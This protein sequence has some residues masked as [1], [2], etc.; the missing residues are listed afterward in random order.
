MR[1]LL[2]LLLLAVPAWAPAWAQGRPDDPGFN[3]GLATSVFT[4]ALSFM[5]PRTIEAVTIPQ[6]TLWGL[7]GV[8]ALD[9]ALTV[10]L[11][12]G[13]IVLDIGG[14]AHFQR[15]APPLPSADAWAAAAA[16]VFNA[17]WDASPALRREGTQGAVAA[18]FDELFNHLDP[19]SRYVAPDAADTDRTRRSGEAGAGMTVQRRAGALVVVNVN[20]DGP[21]GAAGIGVGDRNTGRGRPASGRGDGR[22]GGWLAGGDGGHG[23][24]HHPARTRRAHAHR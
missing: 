2:V 7:D 15:G 20:A 21:A 6:L 24:L 8:T 14:K 22:H 9:T 23:C 12:D 4:A 1:L 10:Q 13:A 11:R 17:A 19:Y 18:F 16:D 5:A 3:A